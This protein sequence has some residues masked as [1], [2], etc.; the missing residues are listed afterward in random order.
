M[1]CEQGLSGCGWSA[2]LR[3]LAG[4]RY[5]TFRPTCRQVGSRLPQGSSMLWRRPG[6]DLSQVRIRAAAWALATLWSRFRR[7]RTA[8]MSNQAVQRTGASRSAQTQIKR[9]RRLAP[10]A[11]LIVRLQMSD[12]TPTVS[13]ADLD[14][15][16]RRDYPHHPETAIWEILNRYGH[17]E[18]YRIYAAALKEGEGDLSKLERAIELANLDYRD[19]LMAAEYPN[20]AQQGY[21][22]STSPEIV[23]A[24]WSQY[25][26]WFK[27]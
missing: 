24:D 4:W 16:I 5:M 19:L 12:Y 26:D 23:E 22:A 3:L 9:H 8:R 18:A 6:R 25:S 10:V 7:F 2:P 17:G 13:Q 15:I 14:R 1:A 21:S 27:K 11:D 20:Q